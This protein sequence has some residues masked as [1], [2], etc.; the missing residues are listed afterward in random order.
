MLNEQGG[1]L[2][3]SCTIVGQVTNGYK[4]GKRHPSLRASQWRGQLAWLVEPEGDLPYLYLW[5]VW[6]RHKQVCS[7]SSP[8]AEG[9]PRA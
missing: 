2:S 8:H 7:D 9:G 4:R 3:G 5:R 6:S 1:E